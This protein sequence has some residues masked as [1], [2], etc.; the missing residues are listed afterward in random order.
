MLYFLYFI[1]ILTTIN[2]ARLTTKAYV[3][4]NLNFDI[5]M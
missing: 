5:K 1:I 3:T 2:F 4:D